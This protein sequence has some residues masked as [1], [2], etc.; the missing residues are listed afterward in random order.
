MHLTDTNPVNLSYTR[1]ST[2]IPIFSVL[3]CYGFCHH[4]A[5]SREAP[6]GHT[7]KPQAQTHSPS[8]VTQPDLWLGALLS[9]SDLLFGNNNQYNSAAV[10][11]WTAVARPCNTT[12]LCKLQIWK[13]NL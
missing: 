7:T 9:L 12:K 13:E 3:T 1:T 2:H 5:L 11:A 10:Q 6:V 4:Q 8:G